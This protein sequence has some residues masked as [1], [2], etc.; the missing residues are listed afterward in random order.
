MN[1]LQED[2]GAMHATLWSKFIFKMKWNKIN[3]AQSTLAIVETK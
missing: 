2:A 3:I 1:E